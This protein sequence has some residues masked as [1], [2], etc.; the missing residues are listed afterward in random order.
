MDLEPR[1]VA[2]ITRE[3]GPVRGW[4]R[5]DVGAGST[6]VFGLRD[7]AGRGWIVKRFGSVRGFAQE[8]RALG[9]WLAGRSELGGARVPRLRAADPKLAALILERL[10]GE[11]VGDDGGGPEVQRAAGRFLAGLHALAS[12]D[13]DPLPI[14]EALERRARA[15]R[16]R[17]ALEPELVELVERLGPRAD[18]FAGVRRVPCHRDFAPR[19]WLWDGERLAVL[20]F[21]H[22]RLDLALADLCKLW[23]DLWS[24]SLDDPGA[25]ALFAG[26]GRTLA[27]AERG[28][29]RALVVLHGLSSLVWGR[30]HGNPN[31]I[32]EGYR[33]LALAANPEPRGS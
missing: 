29:L 3:L 23:V 32:A 31:H 7:A 16:T 33:A 30:Q 20:D 10:P 27:P 26:Y 17:G 5:L 18:Q 15:W 1:L 14:G 9:A 4:T 11:G 6:A 21:E 25:L 28:R 13:D 12:A 24:G 2:W 22:A 8:R 19:N